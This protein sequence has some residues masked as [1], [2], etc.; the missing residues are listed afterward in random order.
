[1]FELIHFVKIQTIRAD[2]INNFHGMLYIGLFDLFLL[3]KFF[4]IL[5]HL[6]C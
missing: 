2:E 6:L 1:M 5:I 4:Q 3:R